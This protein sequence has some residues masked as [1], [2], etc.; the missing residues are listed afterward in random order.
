MIM[1]VLCFLKNIKKKF[2]STQKYS[3]SSYK[4]VLIKI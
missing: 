3:W 2:H 1:R 4:V